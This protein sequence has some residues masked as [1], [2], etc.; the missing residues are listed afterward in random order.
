MEGAW[1]RIEYNDVSQMEYSAVLA[2]ES[3]MV[4]HVTVGAVNSWILINLVI[5]IEAI[6]NPLNVGYL[7]LWG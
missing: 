3:R 7:L 5:E 4:V 6:D 1:L 2:R